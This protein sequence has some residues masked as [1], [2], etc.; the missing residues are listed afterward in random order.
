MRTNFLK[1]LQRGNKIIL[2]SPWYLDHIYYGS[3]WVKFYNLDFEII[4]NQTL[5]SLILGGEVSEIKKILYY[6][7]SRKYCIVYDRYR[8]IGRYYRQKWPIISADSIGKPTDIIG[9][10]FW[11]DN[12]S[13]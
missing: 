1:I 13:F 2:S 10:G 5:R 4:T 11:R 12:C 7:R 8:Y 6:D 3:D 9:R